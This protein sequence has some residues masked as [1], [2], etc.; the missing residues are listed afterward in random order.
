MLDYEW[1]PSIVV[2]FEMKP[3]NPT[4]PW[5]PSTTKKDIDRILKEKSLK[6]KTRD[7]SV[8]TVKTWTKPKPGDVVPYFEGKCTLQ[9]YVHKTNR[10]RVKLEDGSV[11]HLTNVQIR[12]LQQCEADDSDTNNMSEATMK[13]LEQ[14]AEEYLNDTCYV[15]ILSKIVS[16]MKDDV[17][18]DFAKLY[19]IAIS[20]NIDS[21]FDDLDEV[22][23]HTMDQILNVYD[24]QLKY[25]CPD[26]THMHDLKDELLK[27][28]EEPY[29]LAI[30]WYKNHFMLLGK[31]DTNFYIFDPLHDYPLRCYYR[32]LVEFIEHED[33]EF[34]WV[35]D[36]DVSYNMSWY[37]PVQDSV[38]GG[39]KRKRRKLPESHDD[40]SEEETPPRKPSKRRRKNRSQTSQRRRSKL[41]KAFTRP[42]RKRTNMTGWTEEQKTAH[43]QKKL[44]EKNDRNNAKKNKGLYL[45]SISFSKY[46]SN[47]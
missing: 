40:S 26:Q 3:S 16:I 24:L 38:Q 2:C 20:Q 23:I 44:K 37:L 45:S 34:F 8:T 17:E 41:S 27:M 47:F 15:Q 28:F 29:Y 30:L 21:L 42:K 32:D 10:W 25:L 43:R 35:Q 46:M 12:F 19:D 7:K 11:D 31:W 9:R 36:L 18:F 4:T 1:L 13:K 6:L 5:T 22:D 33:V 39:A 14:T